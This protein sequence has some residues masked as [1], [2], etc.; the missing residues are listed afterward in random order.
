MITWDDISSNIVYSKLTGVE[1]N[2]IF[3]EI[4]DLLKYWIPSIVPDKKVTINGADSYYYDPKNKYL[5]ID[6]KNIWSV[7]ESKYDM[8]YYD[9]QQLITGYVVSTHNIEVCD[10][11]KCYALI[12]ISVV[13]THNIE[14]CD[15]Y[16]DISNQLKQVVST[17]N[18]EVCDTSRN[19]RVIMA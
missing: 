17:H 10:T 5:W 9:I 6:Y 1:P 2:P 4:Y 3:K 16:D 7:F 13:S 12:Y 19:L 11:S 8:E 14:V 18:I 15:T